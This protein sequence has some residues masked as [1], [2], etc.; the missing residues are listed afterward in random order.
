VN[1]KVIKCFC[2]DGYEGEKCE[3]GKY[4]WWISRDF[5][6]NEHAVRPWRFYEVSVKAGLHYQ[7]F[8]HPSRN[9]ASANWRICKKC[10]RKL[11]RGLTLSQLWN[12]PMILKSKIQLQ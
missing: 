1:G 6:A 5:I 8:C 2:D 10:L 7:S 3:H 4:F 12:P 11:T 9:F